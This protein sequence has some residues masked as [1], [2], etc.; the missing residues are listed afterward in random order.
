MVVQISILP[1]ADGWFVNTIIRSRGRPG[2]KP[3]KDWTDRHGRYKKDRFHVDLSS[4]EMDLVATQSTSAC[5]M[6]GLLESRAGLQCSLLLY[7]RPYPV[8]LFFRSVG[9]KVAP[10]ATWLTPLELLGLLGG[11]SPY[12]HSLL[13]P[14]CST[15]SDSKIAWARGPDSWDPACQLMT[16]RV[17][18]ACPA[19]LIRRQAGGSQRWTVKNMDCER[20]LDGVAPTQ[21]RLHLP[22]FLAVRGTLSRRRP[23][24]SA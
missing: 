17:N 18:C 1:L 20:D 13:P 15:T 19:C 16:G 3:R 8:H 14:G 6:A 7:T 4:G 24:W 22:V 11:R 21:V 12:M 10:L 5:A 23:A 2:V 9:L